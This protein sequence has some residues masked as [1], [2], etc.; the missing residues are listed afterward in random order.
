M[1]LDLGYHVNLNAK[2]PQSKMHAL[3]PI[4]IQIEWFNLK[5]VSFVI[6]HLSI[7]LYWNF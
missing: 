4:L 3:V 2:L 7:T 6:S 5:K 1:Q